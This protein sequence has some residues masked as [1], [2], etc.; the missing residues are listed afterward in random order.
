MLP[1]GSHK[2]SED[3]CL[4]TLSE[5]KMTT[6]EEQQKQQQA[7]SKSSGGTRSMHALNLVRNKSNKAVKRG[8]KTGSP[9]S[10]EPLLTNPCA[11]LRRHRQGHCRRFRGN[12]LLDPCATLLLRHLLRPNVGALSSLGCP[13]SSPPSTG[14]SHSTSR[15]LAL[16]LTP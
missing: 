15:S 13:S 8:V 4:F 3:W 9:N 12:L 11:T 10:D 7:S 16:N 2:V 14:G 5:E 6:E 1:E